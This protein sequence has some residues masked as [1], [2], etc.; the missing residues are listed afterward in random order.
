MP[1]EPSV[2]DLNRYFLQ[3]RLP[4]DSELYTLD[5]TLCVDFLG[6]YEHLNEDIAEVCRRIGI[7]FDGW[8]P[9]TDTT[10]STA[11]GVSDLTAEHR[12]ITD[13]A[14]ARELSLRQRVGRGQTDEQRVDT[15]TAD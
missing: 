5:G 4:H 7:P 11:I 10:H 12:R 14:F 13:Q 1:G 9:L 15:G 6:R 8:L 2:E 3:E